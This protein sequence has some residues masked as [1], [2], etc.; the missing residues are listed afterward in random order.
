MIYKPRE[1]SYL[2]ASAVK[3]YAYGIVLDM[4]TGTG[5]LAEVAA[6]NKNVKKVIA[7][8][9]D[10]E[11]IEYCKNHISNSKIKFVESDLFSNIHNKFDTIIFNP[12]YLPSE[13][14]DIAIDGGIHGYEL[15][16]RFFSVVNS[17][18]KPNG[19]IL[20]VFSSLTN[21]KQVNSIIKKNGFNY[22]LLNKIHIFFEDI[23]I[24]LIK[25]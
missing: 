25:R 9:I 4:G 13:N 1:D 18:L 3:K 8:D 16:A 14:T 7:V 19:I 21:K 11:A 15:I 2:L 12:P 10:K 24:Y 17:F 23:F 22:K 20:M 6:K 5:F